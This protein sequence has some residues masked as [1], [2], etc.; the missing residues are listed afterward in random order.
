MKKI[1]LLLLP[2]LFVFISA[3]FVLAAEFETGIVIPTSTEAGGLSDKGV[4]EILTNF[5]SWL[6]T[7]FVILAVISFVGSGLIYITSGGDSS[8]AETAKNWLVYSIIGVVVALLSLVI[9]QALLKL[10]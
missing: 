7:A 8:R 5:L 4:V 9:V 10:I 2:I 1:F 3:N 6:L